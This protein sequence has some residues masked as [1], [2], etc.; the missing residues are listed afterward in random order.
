MFVF[1]ALSNS[2]FVLKHIQTSINTQIQKPIYNFVFTEFNHF[3]IYSFISNDIVWSLHHVTTRLIIKFT[4]HQ[5]LIY[6]L[7]VGSNKD[8]VQNVLVG[9]L[10]SQGL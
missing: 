1:S 5:L 3:Y 4:I 7:F 8:S 6:I 2:M 10:P 9:R